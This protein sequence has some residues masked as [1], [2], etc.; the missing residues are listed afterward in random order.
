MSHYCHACWKQLSKAAILGSKVQ[1]QQMRELLSECL[2]NSIEKN[3]PFALKC[4]EMFHMLLVCTNSNIIISWPH[5]RL[6][7]ENDGVFGSCMNA[8]CFI[9]PYH[10]SAFDLYHITT[11]SM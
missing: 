4:P 2:V 8:C 7:Y 11:K 10:D 9:V 6:N 1:E 3:H 5:Y